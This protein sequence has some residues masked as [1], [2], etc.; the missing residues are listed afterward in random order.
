MKGVSKFILMIVMLLICLV[1]VAI[2]MQNIRGSTDPL[3]TIAQFHWYCNFWRANNYYEGEWAPLPD[4]TKVNMAGY[5][6][7]ALGYEVSSSEDWDRCRQE[8]EFVK[9]EED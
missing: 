9:R 4:G 1:I 3:P 5:C 2:L 6:T 8:C 7:A